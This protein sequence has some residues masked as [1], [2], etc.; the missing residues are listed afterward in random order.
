MHFLIVSGTSGMECAEGDSWS[1]IFSFMYVPIRKMHAA[2]I[3]KPRRFLDLK[4]SS[5]FPIVS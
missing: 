1:N 4:L 2:S 3:F 5:F